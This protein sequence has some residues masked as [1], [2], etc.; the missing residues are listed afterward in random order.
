MHLRQRLP[1]TLGARVTL[2]AVSPVLLALAA[3]LGTFLYLQR[4][5]D[6]QIKDLAHQAAET[7][8][9]RVARTVYI[10]CEAAEQ[11]NQEYLSHSLS[12][13]NDQLQEYGSFQLAR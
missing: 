13:V 6:T 8:V 11:R 9:T 4:H 5:L 12:N 2:V 3:I 7:E 10:L 1:H